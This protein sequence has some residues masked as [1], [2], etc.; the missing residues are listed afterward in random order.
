MRINKLSLIIFIAVLA[1][2]GA[3]IAQ[4][5]SFAPPE[6]IVSGEMLLSVDKLRPGDSFDAVYRATVREGY[7][8]GSADKDALYPA[9]LTVKAPK[10]ITFDE[11]VFPK[12]ERKAFEIAPNEKIPVYEGVVLVRLAGQVAKDANP[13]PVTI[14][15][16]LDT[17][18]CK[19]DQC[20][21]PETTTVSVK[22]E[23]VAPGASV[24]RVNG[25]VFALA[26]AES[27]N[28]ET[29]DAAGQLAGRL[30]KMNPLTRSLLL[31][32]GGL[33]L[34]FTPCVYPMIPVTFGYFSNQSAKK[35]KAALLAAFYVLG[36]AL[37]YSILG[38]I[39][40]MTGG[41]FGAAMQSTPVLLG[42]AAV[43]VL[44]ALS[45]FGLYELQ[46]P[47][48]I[49]SKASGRSGVLG[50]LMM[51]LIFGV[52]AAPC[53]GPMV[54]GLLLLAAK[55][56][57][58]V[59]GFFLFFPLA[60]GI[61]TPLFFIALFSA[62]MPQPGMWMVA[63]KKFAGFL[64]LGVA[65]YFIIPIMP[66]D[67]GRYLVP[68]VIL[69]AGI[70][71]GFMEKSIKSSRRGAA[72]GKAF[73]GVAAAAA[74]FMLMPNGPKMSMTWEPYTPSKLTR[75]AEAGKPAMLDFTA[76]WCGVCK[77][78]EH[79]PFSDHNVIEA[80]NRFTR[81][82]LDG[83]DRNDELMLATVRKYDVK[84]FPTIIFFDSTGKEVKS[85]RVVGFVKPDELIKRMKSVK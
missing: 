55:I 13:G 72:F 11:P 80:A 56:G 23:I 38:A 73:C 60:L 74:I 27:P 78:L 61:G 45:M 82:R 42:I 84:G 9:K 28:G 76:K 49:Q 10:G 29:D 75:A 43:L 48:F 79:G 3:A 47:A 5:E 12:G 51:G 18:G 62:K 17:Q 16:T 19:D 40:A 46:P 67:L 14:A 54:L 33:M 25:S 37:T 77:E 24:E 71:L 7:H 31:Y 21:P 63:V 2:T 81:L 53:V 57:S 52:V 36:I 41:V 64:L 39:A 85:A 70:Y 69:A 44:L 1:A 59:V 50:A 30:E 6:T 15:A 65:A 4:V 83:T 8:I 22:T 35:Q 26:G 68:L 66:D 20:Y 58:P 34:A 32:L